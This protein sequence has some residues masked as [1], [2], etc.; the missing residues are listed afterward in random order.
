MT[1]AHSVKL[2]ALISRIT[3]GGLWR[4]CG[5]LGIKTE[6]AACKVNALLIVLLFWPQDAA[7]FFLS[8]CFFVSY[9]EETWSK[10]M[11]G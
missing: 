7:F 4:S 5:M 11:K 9:R 2:I 8:Q 3:P 6:L 10:E 1:G